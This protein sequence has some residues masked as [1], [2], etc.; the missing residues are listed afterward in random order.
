MLF[1]IIKNEI[2]GDESFDDR[3]TGW[4]CV[5]I[6]F[7]LGS[8]CI[9]AQTGTDV[10]TERYKD[11]EKVIDQIEILTRSSGTSQLSKDFVVERSTLS[12]DILFA[13]HVV[14]ED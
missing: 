2:A 3:R 6:N 8:L 12:R 10:M 11:E 1:T 14:D 9:F 7:V 13:Q 4:I 5:V